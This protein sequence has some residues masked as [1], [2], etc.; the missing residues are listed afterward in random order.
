[1][2]LQSQTPGG[3]KL[4]PIRASTKS[5][6]GGGAPHNVDMNGILSKANV[7]VTSFK[8]AKGN[9]SSSLL[10]GDNRKQKFSKRTATLENLNLSNPEKLYRKLA[11]F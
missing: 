1:M 3:S 4:I 2:N 5:K 10:E 6:V 8:L 9:T 11:N 7:K